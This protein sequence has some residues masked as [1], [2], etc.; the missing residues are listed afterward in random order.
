MS[1]NCCFESI[2]AR[3]KESKRHHRQNDQ[4]SRP[5]TGVLERSDE[6]MMMTCSCQTFHCGILFFKM[7]PA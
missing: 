7:R 2:E 3:S 1:G 5:Y 6:A 4:T